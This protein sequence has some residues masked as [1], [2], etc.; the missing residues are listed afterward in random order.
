[1][2]RQK[3]SYP[4][5]SWLSHFKHPDQVVFFNYI[6]PYNSANYVVASRNMILTLQTTEIW[7]NNWSE[8]ARESIAKYRWFV[9]MSSDFVSELCLQRYVISLC[10]VVSWPGKSKNNFEGERHKFEF[11]E[12]QQK[13]KRLQK[14]MLR[15]N[16]S[17]Q[18]CV[19]S[20]LLLLDVCEEENWLSSMV[21]SFI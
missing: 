11:C 14:I 21:Y 6:Y 8:T 5:R 15:S 16:N 20:V 2:S 1:M 4:K 18:K 7:L 13:K 9:D 10:H 3:R 17:S 12:E 19:S